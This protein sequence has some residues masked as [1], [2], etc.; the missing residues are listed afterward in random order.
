MGEYIKSWIKSKNYFLIEFLA[1]YRKNMLLNFMDFSISY[2][3]TEK[4]PRIVSLTQ[5]SN[6]S[7]FQL[8]PFKFENF[9][10]YGTP[11]CSFEK[12]S[13]TLLK[14]LV[15]FWTKICSNEK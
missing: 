9:P 15:T 4:I 7:H 2:A 8:D 6:V 1:E 13:I 11:Y 3:Q 5:N 12:F 10:K 14:I